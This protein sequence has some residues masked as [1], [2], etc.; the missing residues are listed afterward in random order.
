MYNRWNRSLVFIINLAIAVAI[1]VVKA[2]AQGIYLTGVGAVNRAMGSAAVA[3]PV[4]SAGAINYNPATM[5]ALP[6]SEAQ[7]G[8]EVL[9]ANS[10]VSSRI[11]ALNLSG[12][13]DDDS[14]VNP[15]PTFSLVRKQQGSDLTLGL[16]FFSVAGFR[17]DYASSVTNPILFPQGQGGLGRVVGAAD[18]F[19]LMPAASYKVG[20]GTYLGFA[21]ILT[22][23]RLEANPYIFAGANA[24]G[25]YPAGTSPNYRYGGGFQVGMY[26][27]T[28]AGVNLGVAYKSTQ[29]MES[30]TVNTVD[31]NGLARRESFALNLPTVVSLGASYSAIE[32]LLLAVDVRYFDY[33]NARGFEGRGYNADGSVRGLGWDSIWSVSTGVQYNLI[34]EWAL[35]IGY[36]HNEE[37]IGSNE[38]M[39]NVASPLVTKDLIGV[40]T[41]YE[42]LTDLS[43]SIAYLHGFHNSVSGPIETPMGQVPDTSVRNSTS[44]HAIALALTQRF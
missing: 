30:D 27:E 43:L 22:I 8:L 38:A 11:G 20:E 13:S 26:H 34:E 37:P 28:E 29:W 3:A 41:S 25:T 32:D 18:Y 21:P 44:A 33:G 7:A 6:Q 4:D 5:G 23:A 2:D 15:I 16:G 14:G 35:R 19:Q 9:W 17:T 40:G 12:S 31:E 39:F 1:F 24:D 10:S 42:L 36:T